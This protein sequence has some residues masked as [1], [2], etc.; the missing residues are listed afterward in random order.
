MQ[1][2]WIRFPEDSTRTAKWKYSVTYVFRPT[3]IL[4]ST[5]ADPFTK[6]AR[7]EAFKCCTTVPSYTSMCT[8]WH[9]PIRTFWYRGELCSFGSRRGVNPWFAIP[10]WAVFTQMIHFQQCRC[11]FLL[12]KWL[13]FRPST[14]LM[15]NLLWN[16]T[17]G[18]GTLPFWVN[19][20][21]RWWRI[22]HIIT[23]PEDYVLQIRCYGSATHLSVRDVRLQFVSRMAVNCFKI[24]VK[25]TGRWWRVILT[26]NVT[27]TRYW[28]RG[29][30]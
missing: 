13:H 22:P 9:T 17:M 14:C 11:M 1:T 3:R 20:Y 18:Q 15:T 4:G 25:M 28:V 26:S 2:G 29:P 6:S 8:T 23:T 7:T 10:E 12:K 19:L 30:Y 16:P 5:S 27:P 24:V 21:F